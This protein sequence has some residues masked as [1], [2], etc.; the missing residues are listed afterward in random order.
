MYC[1]SLAAATE[2][3]A[4]LN[5][6]PHSVIGGGVDEQS[7]AP[8]ASSWLISSPCDLEGHVGKDG[9]SYLLDFSR[10]MPPIK[11]R[12]KDIF[13]FLFKYFGFTIGVEGIGWL[14]WPAKHSL[15]SIAAS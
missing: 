2:A 8:K 15:V 9:R 3:S 5:L 12:Q 11:V 4:I 1:V 13:S 6:K 14:E 7:G 10:H